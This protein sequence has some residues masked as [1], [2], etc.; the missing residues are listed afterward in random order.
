MQINA[1]ELSNVT[2]HYPSFTLDHVTLAVP[3]GTICGLVGENGAG[4]ST[5]IRLV[6]NACRADEGEIRVLGEPNTGKGFQRLKEDIGVVLDEAYFP[7]TMSAKKVGAMMR[8]TY[9]RWDSARYGEL[10][11][12]FGLPENKAFSTYSRGM[13]MKLGL[14][15]ALSHQPR[16]LI[17]DEATSGLDPMMREELLDML[18]E[19]TRQE[20][21]SILMSSHIVSDL[22]KVCDYIACIHQGRLLMMEE[23]DRLM[24]EYALLKLSREQL[25][26]VPPEAIVAKREEPYGVQLL[27]K[28]ELVSSAWTPEHATLED[29]ILLLVRCA[30]KE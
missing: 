5:L 1:L 18:L 24:E 8:L 28:R 25:E 26:A 23:K 6:M 15:V 17:L 12:R 21:H 14:A 19:F 10:L 11:E 22:E 2:K 29:L 9:Q 13:R 20:D 4:K 3:Q 30:R 16:L 7:G 27:V